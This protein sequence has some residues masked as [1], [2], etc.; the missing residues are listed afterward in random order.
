MSRWLYQMSEAT[1]PLENYK[2]QVKEGRPVRWPTRRRMFAHEAPAA[3]DI[4][5][6]FYA[7]AGCRSPGV[8]GF[9]VITKYLP[10]TRRFNW[11]PLPPTN[12]LKRD[13]W[14]DDRAKEIG[15]LARGN[16]PQG[17]MYQIPGALDTDFR[18]GLFAWANR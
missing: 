14:W 15:D 13:P 18:R 8:C 17:T 6:C 16:A 10:K 11:L 12:R 5:I 4:V 3:G 1:W 9:G 7:P 2:R